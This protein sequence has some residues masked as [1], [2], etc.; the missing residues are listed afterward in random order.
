MY[1]LLADLTAQS[2]KSQQKAASHGGEGRKERRG[3]ASRNG[4]A[5]KQR[6]R[7]TVD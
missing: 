7:D 4:A 1:P 5:E 6:R 2:E 3:I